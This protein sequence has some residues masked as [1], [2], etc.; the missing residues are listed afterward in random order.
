LLDRK[1]PKSHIIDVRE[2]YNSFKT[3]L[4]E[5]YNRRFPQWEIPSPFEGVNDRSVFWLPNG[6]KVSLM[7]AD[8][9]GKFH[10]AG[11][12]FFFMNEMID[13]P[14]S[15]FDQLEQRCRVFWWGDFNP[16]VTDHW[17]Y[18]I[19]FNRDDVAVLKTTWLDNPYITDMEK[20]KI[21]SYD[22]G[23]PANVET[24]T[25]DEYMWKVYGLGQRAALEGLVFGNVTW[26]DSF[27]DNIELVTYGLDFG[28]TQDPT[29]LVKI[30]R[31]GM[32]LY[33]QKLLYTPIDNA[34]DLADTL[35]QLIHEDAHVWADSSDPGMI[36]DLRRRNIRCLAAQKF[37]GSVKYG[38]DLMKRFKIHIVRD[39][40]FRK[41]QENYKYRTIGGIALNEP[42]DKWNHCFDGSRYGIMS[43][44][45]A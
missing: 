40:D 34:N 29:A 4:Y 17:I 27:P 26:I 45:R 13:I 23:N 20:A 21:L 35:K 22:P 28:Y 24:G 39:R 12:D 1:F 18:N 8:S 37:P 32:N 15:I 36:A 43:E 7:G 14:Q 16:K 2:T 41:E 33:L 5:D 6:T 42:E 44:F 19:L 38:I 31:N 10:G 30:G 3:T 11:S 25:A 9:P